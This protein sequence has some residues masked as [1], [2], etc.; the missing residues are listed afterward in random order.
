MD[1]IERQIQIA[2][3]GL[4]EE[5][6]VPI[7]EGNLRQSIK[8]RK[9]GPGSYQVY[10]DEEQAPYAEKVEEMKPFWE[11]VAMTLSY[12]LATALGGQSRREDTPDQR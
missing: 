9:T 1:F 11:R 2:L 8:T 5:A 7:Q 10:V 6:N 4:A 3:S 12:R